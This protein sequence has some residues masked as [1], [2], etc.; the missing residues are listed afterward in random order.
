MSDHTS[1]PEAIER[2]LETTRVRLDHELTELTRRLSPGQL[3]DE[4]LRYLRNNQGVD[5]VRRLTESV[6]ERPIPVALTGIGLAWL[7]IAG[8]RPPERVVYRER[9]VRREPFRSGLG[10]NGGSQEAEDTLVSR[11]WQAGKDVARRAAESDSEYR[12]RVT[13][14]RA[15][16]FGLTRQAQET[17]ETFAERVQEAL[18]AAGARVKETMQGASDQAGSYMRSWRD[19]ASDASGRLGD[20]ASGTYAQAR[21]TLGR[22]ADL[23]D[24][25]SGNPVL[26]GSLGILTGAVLGALFP[27]SEAE[28]TYLGGTARQARDTV[29][30]AA[31]GV[32]D[33]GRD[34]AEAVA[35]ASAEGARKTMD[36]GREAAE[37]VTARENVQPESPETQSPRPGPGREPT[38][39]ATHMGPQAIV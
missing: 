32:M 20:A 22:G 4:T 5:F 11:A 7:M 23:W 25:I 12:A 30:D 39:K 28:R 21:D 24:T 15:K 31:D 17:A 8:P 9:V 6:R 34:V 1:S 19:T 3:L 33:R 36:A 2:D 26:L 29:A 37:T 35:Q 16:V 38:E 10:G 13:E 27:P 14:A 18:S